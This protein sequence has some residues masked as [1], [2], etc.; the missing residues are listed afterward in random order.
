[1]SAASGPARVILVIEVLIRLILA[2]R[3]LRPV[4]DALLLWSGVFRSRKLLGFRI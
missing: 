3:S 1:M 4:G 2:I